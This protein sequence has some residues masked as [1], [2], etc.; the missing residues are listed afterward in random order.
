MAEEILTSVDS[1]EGKVEK[2]SSKTEARQG[3][4]FNIL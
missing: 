3:T 1:S 4:I 2:T